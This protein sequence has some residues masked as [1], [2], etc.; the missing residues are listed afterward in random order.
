MADC[1]D[2]EDMAPAFEG[3]DAVVHLAANAP[4]QTPW[5]D[6]LRNN[7]ASTHNVYEAALANTA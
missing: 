5:P 4:V 7:I 3:Q 2:Y 1:F 6:V